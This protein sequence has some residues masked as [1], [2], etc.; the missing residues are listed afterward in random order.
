MLQARS[1]WVDDMLLKLTSLIRPSLSA[2]SACA[3]RLRMGSG[4]LVGQC[5][6][7]SAV[8]SFAEADPWSS[9]LQSRG[10]RFCQITAEHPC[11]TL[12]RIACWSHLPLLLDPGLVTSL[13]I[14]SASGG[15][16]RASHRR[17]QEVSIRK[18]C[19]TH[20]K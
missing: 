15:T 19:R 12:V 18:F 8:L 7:T 2:C 14:V 6:C 1:G 10:T 20:S 17:A 5:C 3:K 4:R 9:T 13:T 16:G 11:R